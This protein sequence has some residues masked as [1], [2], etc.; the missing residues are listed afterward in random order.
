[1]GFMKNFFNQTGRP[2]GL[3]GKF[4]LSTMNSG[5]AKLADWGRGHLSEISPKEIV[6]LGCEAGR[7]AGELLKRY[8]AATLTAIDYSPLSVEKHRNTTKR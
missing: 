3:L 2:S 5:H 7:N 1:M 8:P 4:M 6:E